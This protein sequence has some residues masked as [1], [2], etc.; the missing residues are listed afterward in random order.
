MEYP[1]IYEL[2][3]ASS[4]CEEFGESAHDLVGRH[5]STN[6]MRAHAQNKGALDHAFWGAMAEAGLIGAGV[7]EASG[8]LG[9]GFEAWGAIAKQLGARLAPDPF[10]ACAVFPCSVL[11]QLALTPQV[12][13]LLAEVLSAQHVCAVAWQEDSSEISPSSAATSLSVADG[14]L[15]LKGEKHWVMQAAEVD[16]VLVHARQNSEPV[17]IRLPL[18]HPG[19]EIRR[20]PRVDGTCCAHYHFDAAVAP[21]QILARGE[22]VDRAVNHALHVARLTIAQE[23]LGIA[24]VV[25]AATKAYLS[26]RVQFSNVLASNQALQHRMVDDYIRISAMTASLKHAY[27]LLQANPG[28]LQEIACRLKA[29][30]SELATDMCRNA[31]QLHGAIGYTDELEIGLYLKRALNLSSQLGASVRLMDVAIDT[32]VAT[33]YAGETLQTAAPAGGECTDL[34]AL[35]E[36]QF[37]AVLYQFLENNYPTALRHVPRRLRLHECRDWYMALS[38]K[39]WLAPAWPREYGGMGLSPEKL[40]QF[41]DVMED[42]G[43]ARLPDQGIINLGPVLIKHGTQEQKNHYLPRILKGE[44]IWCQGYSEPNAGSDLASLRTEAVSDGDFYTVN[45]SK[46]WTTLAHDADF[47]F[48]LV[49]TDKAAKKQA[50]I[51]FLLINLKSPGITVRPITNL[52]GEQ[53][54]CEVF[55]DNVRVPR[56]NVV[57]AENDGWK[58][59]KDLLGH[60]RIFAGSPQQSRQ[61]LSLLQ[62]FARKEALY[63][64]PAFRMTYGKLVASIKELESYYAYFAEFVKRGET[65]PASVSSLKILAT[66]TYVQIA[67]E[68]LRWADIHGG[69]GAELEIEPH[70][71]LVGPAPF[72]QSLVTTIYGGTNEIQRNIISKAV[73]KFPSASR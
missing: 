7:D 51:T 22:A 39:G 42:Y 4:S 34:N 49:R 52:M 55:F 12:A 41:F 2:F 53:E 3:G 38:A 36:A 69:S 60:E 33:Q 57:G 19:V 14:R 13:Q 37:K 66:E 45:G 25:F 6:R 30:A 27:E 1:D 24:Q 50:G 65:L 15:I 43:V 40:L 32:S 20:E 68:L 47:I 70:T 73:L 11:T 48:A 31:V 23:C 63:E 21:E 44:D 9:L 10:V 16:S 5:S 56:S 62:K 67:R 54:F 29:R 18:A 71:R 17:L 28:A 35:P 64:D 8:G 61:A 58:I 26:A 59:A 46:I 72:L